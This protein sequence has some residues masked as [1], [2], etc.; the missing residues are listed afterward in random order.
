[1]IENRI[2]MTA[3]Q[4]LRNECSINGS[5][6][7]LRRNW[8]PLL[9]LLLVSSPRRFVL[10]DEMIS[11]VWPDPDDEPENPYVAISQYVLDM[12]RIGVP[13]EANGPGTREIGTY[14]IP[15]QCRTSERAPRPGY[16][17][18]RALE[19]FRH[20]VRKIRADQANP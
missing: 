19:A 17:K 8:T 10:W 20:R 4:M 15:E 7:H 5:V 2:S 11:A 14:R 12:K 13:I 9:T 18:D 3:P 16:V 1:M 6:V